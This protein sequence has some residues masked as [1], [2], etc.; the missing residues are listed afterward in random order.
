MILAYVPQITRVV[1]SRC[2]VG[3]SLKAYLTW[4]FAASL[5]LSFAVMRGDLVFIALQ[6]YGLVATAVISFFCIRYEHS[7]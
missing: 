7:A 1:G 6:S 2:C 4:G 3:L 5:L